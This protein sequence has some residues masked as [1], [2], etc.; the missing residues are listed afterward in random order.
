MYIVFC[1]RGGYSQSPRQSAM[2]GRREQC[3][4]VVRDS[5][6]APKRAGVSATLIRRRPKRAGVFPPR[7]TDLSFLNCRILRF[8]IFCRVHRFVRLLYHPFSI[9]SSFRVQ[10]AS[11]KSPTATSVSSAVTNVPASTRG[12]GRS[13][14][15]N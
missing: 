13:A 15:A 1:A 2:N 11:N 7:R 4:A 3:S 10:A 8:L 12:Q 9:I 6:G 5:T 14:T